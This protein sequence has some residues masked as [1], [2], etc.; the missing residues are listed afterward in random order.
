MLAHALRTHLMTGRLSIGKRVVVY[1]APNRD[2]R[3]ATSNRERSQSMVATYQLPIP[4]PVP[5]SNTVSKPHKSDGLEH[6]L[7]TEPRFA[8]S[9]YVDKRG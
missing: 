3:G 6:C 2:G 7:K 5:T 8:G 4:T 9:T 1:G